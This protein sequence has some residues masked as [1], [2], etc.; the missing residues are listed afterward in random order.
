MVELHSGAIWAESA[1]QGQGSTFKFA[2]PL[3]A[4]IGK[5]PAEV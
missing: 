2:I 4:A 3:P 1:G 5:A